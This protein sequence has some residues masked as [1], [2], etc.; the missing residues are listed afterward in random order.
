MVVMDL[1]LLLLAAGTTAVLTLLRRLTTD[2]DLLRRCAQDRK[3]L[4]ELRREAKARRDAATVRRLRTAEQ[5]VRLRATSQE[6]RPLLA[7][8]APALLLGWWANGWF[9]RRPIAG[10]APFRLSAEFAPSEA[11]AL[12]H[13]VPVDG[14]TCEGSWIRC[15]IVGEG[16]GAGRGICEWKL[17]AAARAEPYELV[18][19][20]GAGAARLSVQVAGRPPHGGPPG[21]VQSD[22]GSFNV[23]LALGEYRFLR[24]VPG[25]RALGLPPWLVAYLALAVPLM[26]VFRRILRVC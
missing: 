23:R 10:G 20:H 8:L 16:K 26:A 22:E 2:Q 5:A 12:A 25:I 17:S 11:G 18:V 14:M 19:R 3:R 21:A 13:V 24:I 6:W 15:I 4:R 9:S 1:A 7:A